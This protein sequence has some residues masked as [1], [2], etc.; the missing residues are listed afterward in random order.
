MFKDRKDAGIQLAKKLIGY[1]N[2]NVVVLAIPRGGLPLGAIVAE[3]LNAPLDIVLTKKI[4]HP[5]NKEFAIGA[6]SLQGKYVANSAEATHSYIEEETRRIRKILR[7]RQDQYYKNF[8]PKILKDKIVI[9]VDDGVATGSTIL[10]TVS[11][12]KEEEPSKIVVAFP[13]GSSSAINR[14]YNSP[15]IDEV[16][17]I[18]VPKHFNAVGQF[19]RNFNPVLDK[20]AMQILKES[21]KHFIVSK[22]E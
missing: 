7:Q 3:A 5:L 9:V 11:L 4:G 14:L 1:K 17:C 12:I 10:A 8:A 19:Y 21:N 16:V 18:E 15:F 22:Y 20:K 13:V 6:V 2:K